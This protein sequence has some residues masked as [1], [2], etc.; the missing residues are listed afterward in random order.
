MQTTQ[1]DPI[2]AEVRAVRDDHAARFGYDLEAIFR[3]IRSRQA[4]SGRAYVRYPS[5]PAVLD[6][7]DQA[8]P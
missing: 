1:I 3:D 8:T 5:R 2:I 4:A 7:E 6:L